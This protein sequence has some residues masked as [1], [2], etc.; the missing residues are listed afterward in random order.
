MPVETR[1]HTEPIGG[2]EP[3]A[4]LP[5][6]IIEYSYRLNRPGAISFRLALDH[7]LCTR[8]NVGD[9]T[10]AVIT[11]NKAVV[12]RGPVD[13]PSETDETGNRFVDFGG[14]GLESYLKQWH[15]TTTLT[16][17]AVDQFT[18]ARGLVAHHQGKAGGNF[19]I[20]TSAVNLSGVVRD[21]T[22]HGVELKNI[23]EAL[24]ELAEVENGFDFHVDPASREL[25][26]HYP[27]RGSRKP[28]L[29][30][31]ERTIRKFARTVDRPGQA[32]QVLGVGAGEGDAML[33]RDLQDAGAAAAH[34]LTQRVYTAKTVNQAATLEG[35]V[36]RELALTAR[37]PERY[38]ITV[39]TTD[40]P[41]FSWQL[42]DEA[43]LRWASSYDPVNALVRIVGLD[44]GWTKGEEQAV[45]HV[46]QVGS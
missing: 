44:V 29:I 12:W 32:S 8:A 40:P 11:R 13:T 25:V 41:L 36:R 21:R 33:R 17:A 22:Y 4:E 35:H 6:E 19:G 31:D 46:E 10:E 39:G 42:G 28:D 16:H 5:A 20:D 37:P 24:V 38:S 7:P 43:Q 18:I 26:L 30:F 23:F 2:G 34:K 9:Q 45:L 15:V 3:I 27:R 1:L 14:E